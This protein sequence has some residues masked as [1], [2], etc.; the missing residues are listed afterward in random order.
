[1]KKLYIKK[2]Q[3]L[4]YTFPGNIAVGE[5]HK[6][7]WY[8]DA[9]WHSEVSELNYY[10]PFTNTYGTNTIW[11]ESEEDKGDFTPIDCKLW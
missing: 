11:V 5:Y 8:R 1:M 4:D 3:H 10:L 7:K 2:Y 9:K 6:D